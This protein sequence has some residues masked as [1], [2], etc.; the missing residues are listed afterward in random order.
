MQ[1]AGKVAIITGSGGGGSGRAEAVR[2]ARDGASV[3][4]SDVNEAGGRETVDLINRSGG[5]AAVQRA[6]VGIEAEVKALV[7]FAEKTFGGLDVLVNNASAPYEPQG[8]L[9]GWFDAVQVDLL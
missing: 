2:M 9:V 4:V 6:D 7:S 8:P 5:R 1:L 3:V